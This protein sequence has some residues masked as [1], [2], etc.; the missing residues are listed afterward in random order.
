M[1]R[2]RFFTESGVCVEVFEAADETGT[3]LVL[4][5]MPATIGESAL[6][7][8]L[9]QAGYT[10]LQPHYP[11]TY[12]SRGEFTPREAAESIN[13]IVAAVGHGSVLDAKNNA[14]RAIR[15]HVDVTIGYSFGAHIALRTGIPSRHLLLISPAVAYGTDSTGF[16]EEDAS[17][18]DYPSRSR[19]LTYRVGD[20][21]EWGAFYRGEQNRFEL[22]ESQ[23][24]KALVVYGSEDSSLQSDRLEAGIDEL[25]SRHG[26]ET[27]FLRIDGGG[28]SASSLLT[29]DR[30]EAILG[31]LVAWSRD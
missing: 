26:I 25:L 14:A 1:G 29:H 23:C 10:V 27:R 28:H 30:D 4:L 17:F 19:P 11:G 7:R 22:S 16:G 31:G 21:E 18:L 12:D 2:Y 5:G 13:E 20:T 24:L 6:T 3:A 8:L 15:N 9:N